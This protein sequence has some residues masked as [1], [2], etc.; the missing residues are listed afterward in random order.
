M[1]GLLFGSLTVLY[2]ILFFLSSSP[3]LS[4]RRFDN[5]AQLDAPRLVSLEEVVVVLYDDDDV[6]WLQPR[7]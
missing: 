1:F 3:Y 6:A 2:Y 5:F 7:V 4:I